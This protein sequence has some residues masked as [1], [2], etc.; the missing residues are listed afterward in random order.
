MV[1]FYPVQTEDGTLS[2]FN[3]KINDIYHSKIGA[4]TEALNKFTLPSGI[5][6]YARNNDSISI[7][8]I[9]YGLGYNSR[10]AVNEIWKVNPKC[11]IN[12]TGIEIDPYVIACSFLIN[13]TA[14]N[15]ISKKIFK[16]LIL[17][18]PLT[19]RA[20][21]S[22][23]NDVNFNIENIPNTRPFLRSCKN[24]PSKYYIVTSESMFLHNIYYGSV[25][26]RNNI[27]SKLTYN[28][29]LLDLELYI[30]DV[31]TQI[32]ALK[33][34]YNYIFHDPFTPS[35][36]PSLWTVDILKELYRLLKI[37]G[38]LTT[39][40]SSAAVRSGM[41]QAGFYIGTTTPIGRKSSGTIA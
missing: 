14:E 16:R 29:G 2:L 1:D 7:L 36:L 21:L 18:N 31:R 11:R 26:D 32:R 20:L 30:E 27:S 28:K 3:T 35:I 33:V 25:S 24:K 8:D 41:I 15:P 22:L 19:R 10:V 34:P 4:Y 5:V 13:I 23:Y 12:V 17:S 39:Y 9:C 38:N 40:T 6:E 37:D